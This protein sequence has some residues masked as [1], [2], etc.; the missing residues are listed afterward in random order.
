MVIL[1]VLCFYTGHPNANDSYLRFMQV[2]MVAGT[3][4]CY[5]IDLVLSVPLSI[6]YV[7]PYL[8]PYCLSIGAVSLFADSIV[9]NPMLSNGLSILYPMP[10]KY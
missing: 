8:I 2:G 9:T 7:I 6:P 10:C 1:T 3:F 4:Q 5:L